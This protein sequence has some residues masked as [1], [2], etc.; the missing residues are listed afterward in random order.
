M[1]S[2]LR[3]SPFRPCATSSLTEHEARRLFE[4]LRELRARG[5][6]LIFVSH[7]LDEVFALALQPVASDLRPGMKKPSRPIGQ[8]AAPSN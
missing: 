2:F 4:L 8:V 3:A 7:K 1:T 5:V 6:A